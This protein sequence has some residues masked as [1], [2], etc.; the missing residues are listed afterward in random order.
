MLKVFTYS[1]KMRNYR[2]YENM[3]H[4]RANIFHKRMNWD[5]VVEREREEDDY[6][7]EH[8]PL[9]IVAERPDGSH[10]TSMRL[11]PTTG[12]TMLRDIFYKFF[13]GCPDIY[14]SNIWEATRYCATFKKGDSLAYTGE[15]FVRLSEI[16]LGSGIDIV[17]GVFFNPMLRVL[18]KS[19]WAPTPVMTSE[20]DGA[21]ITLGT[22]E[23]S[24][25]RMHDIARRYSLQHAARS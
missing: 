17:T 6:D 7:R 19:G 23:I 13:P 16:C 10:V 14:A 24:E 8:N 5:V 25:R 3:V 1:E 22:S 4:A 12:P 2:S 11:L 15:L 9:Y 18:N 21:P 20:Y